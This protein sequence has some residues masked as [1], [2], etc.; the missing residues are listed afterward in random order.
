MGVQALAAIAGVYP[1]QIVP[2]LVQLS[3]L[4]AGDS[5][6]EEEDENEDDDMDESKRESD[7]DD[8]ESEDEEETEAPKEENRYTLLLLVSFL[9]TTKFVDSN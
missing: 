1:L 4:L 5:L 8:S 7:D 2:R 9:N 6:S 3:A